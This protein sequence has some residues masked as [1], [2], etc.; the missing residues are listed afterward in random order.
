MQGRLGPLRLVEQGVELGRDFLQRA[1]LVQYLEHP[2]RARFH[3]PARQFLPHALG[4]ERI[5]F[6]ARHHGAHERFGFGR[7]VEAEARGE[8][9]DAQDA[10]RV[11]GEGRAHVAQDAGAQVLGAVERIDEVAVLVARDRV[12]REIAARE[13]LLERHVGRRMELEAVIAARGLA[14]GA[15]ERVLLVRFGMKKNREILAD[16]TVAERRPSRPGVAPTTT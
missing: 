14:L 13:V 4:N 6:A 10:H 8:A 2:R 12:D 1:A 5:D 16:R 11:L 3:E 15:R 7:D 9:R